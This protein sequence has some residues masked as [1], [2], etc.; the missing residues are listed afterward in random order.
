MIHNFWYSSCLIM[1]LLF[2]T[3]VILTSAFTR[4][5]D[6]Y[7]IKLQN[8]WC[9]NSVPTYNLSCHLNFLLL[10]FKCCWNKVQFQ[11]EMI[12]FDITS[13]EMILQ[14]VVFSTFQ[15]LPWT[16]CLFPFSSKYPGL[17]KLLKPVTAARTWVCLFL[18]PGFQVLS[19]W[20]V[21]TLQIDCIEFCFYY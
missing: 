5:S 16:V 3:I 2:V 12:S 8:W 7:R 14:K 13:M 17:F 6:N 20:L 18:K 9:L 19:V 21:I 11:V 15:F 10:R 4:V 1:P